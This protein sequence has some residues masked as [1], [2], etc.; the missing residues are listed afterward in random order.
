MIL[1]GRAYQL[2]SKVSPNGP[3]SQN[4][5]QCYDIRTGE[6]FWER[7]LYSGESEPN[8]IEYGESSLA[9]LGEGAKPTVPQ[10]LSIGGGYLRKY[11]PNNG[12]LSFNGSIAAL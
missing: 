6:L 12:A 4:Y 3:G 2:V 7:P 5:W 1:S 9:V 11:N 10:L 8:L